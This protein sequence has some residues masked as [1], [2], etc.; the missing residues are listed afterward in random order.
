LTE[1]KNTFSD[2]DL[3]IYIKHAIF[4]QLDKMLLVVDIDSVV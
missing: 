3:E 4:L 1:G 2:C